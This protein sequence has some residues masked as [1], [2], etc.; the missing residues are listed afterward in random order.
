MPKHFV[1]APEALVEESLRGLVQTVPN[2]ALLDSAKGVVVRSDWDRVEN[3]K[4]QVALISGG[5]TC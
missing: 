1:N 4:H 2:L 5:G 3:G